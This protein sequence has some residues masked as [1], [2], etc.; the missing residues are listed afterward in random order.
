VAYRVEV[1]TKLFV[2]LCPV[3]I[4]ANIFESHYVTVATIPI[5]LKI[6]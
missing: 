6:V 2:I 1:E 3:N 4:S 5:V